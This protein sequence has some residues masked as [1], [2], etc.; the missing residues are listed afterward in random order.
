MI[1]SMMLIPHPQATRCRFFQKNQLKTPKK[2]AKRS[3]GGEKGV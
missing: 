1:R 3:Q 2:Q